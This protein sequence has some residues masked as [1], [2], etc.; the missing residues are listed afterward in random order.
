MTKNQRNNPV[1][2]KIIFPITLIIVLIALIFIIKGSDDSKLP[3][4]LNLDNFEVIVR[5]SFVSDTQNN[6]SQDSTKSSDSNQLGPATVQDLGGS[7]NSPT[8]IDELL[9]DK[10]IEV[11][12]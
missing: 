7:S 9:K 12:R 10:Q 5:D 11:G 4:D 6:S 2:F 1:Y 8:G 3:T